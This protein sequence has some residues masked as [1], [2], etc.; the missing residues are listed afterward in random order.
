MTYEIKTILINNWRVDYMCM[1]FLLPFSMHFFV[2]LSAVEV[3][4]SI[5]LSLALYECESSSKEGQ[6]W[7][8][9][10]IVCWG[11]CLNLTW[12]KWEEDGE[13]YIV[14]SVIICNSY[15]RAVVPLFD[16][17]SQ[18]DLHVFQWTSAA[19]HSRGSSVKIIVV[20]LAT[21]CAMALTTVVM[22]VTKTTWPCVL[23]VSNPATFTLSTSVQTKS[24]SIAVECVTLLMTVVILL[25]NLVAVSVCL[26]LPG[27]WILN[28][29]VVWMRGNLYLILFLGFIFCIWSVTSMFLFKSHLVLLHSYISL[30]IAVSVFRVREFETGCCHIYL[31]MSLQYVCVRPRFPCTT[32]TQLIVTEMC[33][34]MLEQLQ[35]T[36]HDHPL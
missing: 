6:G 14:R 20:C 25:M 29:T 11:D 8:C 36:L 33:I 23:V 19:M 24:A 16:L 32:F 4:N 15:Q 34:E 22:A 27:A 3:Q 5:I 31:V 28:F 1:K 2:F 35:H 18:W 7:V 21:S 26:C 30:Y 13:N 10:R 9:L 12:R 17:I